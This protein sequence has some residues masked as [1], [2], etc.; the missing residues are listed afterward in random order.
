MQDK[1]ISLHDVMRLFAGGNGKGI[2]LSITKA[3][4]AGHIKVKEKP[5]D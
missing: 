4:K 1:Y 5:H 3:I 2:R